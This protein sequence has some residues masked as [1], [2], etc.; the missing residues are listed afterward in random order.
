MAEAD[1][2][3]QTLLRDYPPHYY[4]DQKQRLFEKALK[5]FK[6]Q[7]GTIKVSRWK[8]DTDQESH[9]LLEKLPL[10]IQTR[11]SFFTYEE[12]D[13][14]VDRNF[15]LNYA[16]PY[17]FGYYDSDL[18]A[19]D[20][21][22]TL[23]HPLLA[24]VADYI[25]SSP[26]KAMKGLTVEKGQPT[27]F[28]VEDVPQ[29]LSVN[30]TPVLP[31][32]TKGNIYGWM[33]S[34]SDTATIDA[35]IKPLAKERRNSIIAIAAPSGGAG[36]YIKPDIEYLLQTILSGFGAAANKTAEDGRQSIAIHTGRWGCGAF[37]N[38]EELI[39]LAQII[40]AAAT[41]ISRIVF[42]CIT[43]EA[44]EEAKRKYDML[45][46]WSSFDDA[47][48]FLLSQNYCWNSPDGN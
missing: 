10:E 45:P 34:E 27:P 42:H 4:S 38:N 13:T 43:P 17:L 23:E 48:Q 36:E 14:A 5:L 39:H 15:Y 2:D 28:V 12:S 35:G 47:V 29:W 33:F 37:G 16:D 40:G 31:D 46:R 30:T 19:Q 26:D 24:S 1:L 7:K 21:I 9:L 18:F 41:G 3:I 20:E 32:G 44:L 8:F 6:E 22:Q 11:D 25:E